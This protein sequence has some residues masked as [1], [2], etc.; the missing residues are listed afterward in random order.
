VKNLET[1]RI[2]YDGTVRDNADGAVVQFYYGDDGLDVM[3]VRGGEGRAEEST[4][5]SM[6]LHKCLL[7]LCTCRQANLQ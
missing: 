5:P 1:L 7:L 3:Q 2:Q 4:G 6:C